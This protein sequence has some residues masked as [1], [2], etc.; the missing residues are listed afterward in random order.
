MRRLV[1]QC[2]EVAG[3]RPPP[4]G[5]ASADAIERRIV[6]DHETDAA[7]EAA[8]ADAAE[9]S[10]GRSLASSVVSRAAKALMDPSELLI[11]GLLMPL[12]S[13]IASTSAHGPASQSASADV[14]A[15]LS[16]RDGDVVGWFGVFLLACACLS[17]VAWQKVPGSAITIMG[18]NYNGP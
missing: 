9:R 16:A 4:T 7:A 15:K 2:V 17:C 11:A 13:T 8:V 12:C 10:V 1:P 18:H 6:I 5:A 14:L 3:E